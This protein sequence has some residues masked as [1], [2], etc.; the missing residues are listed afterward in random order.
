MTDSVK[1]RIVILGG[2][3]GGLYTAMKLEKLLSW[4]DDFEIT[5]INNE[6]YFVYQPMLAEIIS[7]NVGIFD[8]I[9]PLRQLLKRTHILVRD[10][11]N[12]DL[13]NRVVICSP[14]FERVY[15]RIP[16]DHLVLTLGNVTDFRGMTG[17]TQHALRFKTLSDALYLRNHAIHTLEEASIEQDPDRR[18]ALLTFVVAG[19]GWSGVECA[20]ELNNFVRG[21][22]VNYH[23]LDPGEIKVILLHSGE[24][25]LEQL[26]PN[27]R[28]L[29]QR[30]LVH[31]GVDIRLKT[32]LSAATGSEAILNTGE[33]IA[34]KTLVSTVPSSP[35]P[36]TDRT[37]LPKE[38]G[39]IRTDQQMQVE[40]SDHLWSLGDCAWIPDPADET[41]KIPCPPTAQHAV[42]QGDVAAYNIVTTIRGG[43][44]KTFKFKGL[45]TMG[46]LGHHSAVAQVMG[47]KISGL[48]AWF[49]WRAIYL[50]KMPG[51]DRRVR[52][53]FGWI[54]SNML[55]TDSVQLRVET[56][57]GVVP[58]TL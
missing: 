38:R 46:A 2:G 21:I 18:Q 30:V 7:G 31:A 50:I 34:T 57:V 39:R 40:G 45:G 33:R 1:K 10:V 20:A 8:T 54:V 27:L 4:H 14:G 19:G 51:W 16:Y 58:G 24:T 37:N 13:E 43:K 29:A 44:R 36:V 25:I 42:R 41:G 26:V 22:A 9:S 53:M 15:T 28:V 48:P 3:F 35:N 49:M 32:R 17:F 56:G 47:L 5:L 23:D 55:P 6:N 52:T 11:E 12:I